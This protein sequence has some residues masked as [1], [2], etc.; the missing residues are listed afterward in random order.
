[1][2]TDRLRLQLA[3]LTE[4]DRLKLVLRRTPL[5]DGSRRENSAEHS[6]HIIVCAFVLR[7]H[8]AGSLDLLRTLQMLAVHDI[9][10]VDAGD[11]FA[12][13]IDGHQSKAER[14]QAAAERLFGM[15]P[16]DQRDEL[17]ALW[18]EFEA[19]QTVEAKLAN[20]VDRLQPL[21]LNAAAGGGS[22][23]DS[24]VTAARVRERMAPLGDAMPALGEFAED[25]IRSFADAGV[26]RSE[27]GR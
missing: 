6:W 8:V 21:L 12:Y 1:M 7:E 15:L 9:V 25:L 4:I 20:A 24:Q 3:F 10:E 13:D 5:S 27:A 23:H 16:A 22:W 26:I 2:L 14:E 19:R 18:V 17:M 11:T